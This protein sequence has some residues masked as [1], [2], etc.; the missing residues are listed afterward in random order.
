MIAIFDLRK[1]ID[2]GGDGN[3][4]HKI[5]LV[6]LCSRRMLVVDFV[7]DVESIWMTKED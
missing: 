1:T 4:D 2:G 6:G 3:E 5:S 7:F